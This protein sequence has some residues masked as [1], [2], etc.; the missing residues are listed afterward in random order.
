MQLIRDI[1]ISKDSASDVLYLEKLYY[2]VKELTDTSIVLFNGT[3]YVM[4][5]INE[6]NQIVVVSVRAKRRDGARTAIWV[7][8]VAAELKYKLDSPAQ[9][10]DYFP[11]PPQVLD[12]F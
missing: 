5:S 9:K 10:K 3:Y 7:Q 1:I 8:K 4:A 12:W 11:K 6:L 2:C